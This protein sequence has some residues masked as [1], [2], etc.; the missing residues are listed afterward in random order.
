MKKNPASLQLRILPLLMT[1]IGA[2]AFSPAG[3]QNSIDEHW[4]TY[5]HPTG[6]F[7]EHPADWRMQPTEMGIA[8]VPPDF[9]PNAELIIALGESA[10]GLAGPT[11]PQVG[12]YFDVL[13]SQIAP[14]MRRAA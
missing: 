7:I 8:L 14:A 1:L 13:M 5:R 10:F 11:D 3:A 6:T 12:Q 2:G 9:D 4:V